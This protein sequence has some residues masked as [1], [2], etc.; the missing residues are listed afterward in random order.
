MAIHA[1]L[2]AYRHTHGLPK[3]WS[4]APLFHLGSETNV[5]TWFS[6]SLLLLCAF[7]LWL[8]RREALRRGLAGATHWL[9]LALIFAYL[10]L[11]EIAA[12]HERT[13]APLHQLF[14]L[15]GVFHFAWVVLAIPILA[16]LGVFYIPFLIRLGRPHRTRFAAAAILYVGGALGM[17]MIGAAENEVHGSVSLVYEVFNTLEETLEMLGTV[18]F[19]HALL[20]YMGELTSRRTV[21]LADIDA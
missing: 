12:I 21:Y 15:T 19:V 2:V 13:D 4:V 1:G 8:I 14:D 9:W 10:S 16:V 3:D 11:D 6:G 20:A 7:L 18:V 5:P 17:E